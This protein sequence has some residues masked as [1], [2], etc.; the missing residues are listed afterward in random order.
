MEK[1]EQMWW[2]AVCGNA[3]KCERREPLLRIG[4]VQEIVWQCCEGSTS[5][6]DVARAVAIARGW[7]F[8][9]VGAPEPHMSCPQCVA[10]RA[11]CNEAVCSG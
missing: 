7:R 10:G 9:Y 3:P 11:V 5:E 6:Q 1:N 4:D 8:E 2:F